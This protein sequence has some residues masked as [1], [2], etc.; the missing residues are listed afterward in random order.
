MKYALKIASPFLF[1]YTMA[2]FLLYS[3]RKKNSNFD[4]F[5]FRKS[6]IATNGATNNL[7]SRWIRASQKNRVAIST[8]GVLADV[9]PVFFRNTIQ[10]K[11]F[12]AFDTTLT[13]G[14]LES[15]KSDLKRITPQK[16]DYKKKKY[17]DDTEFPQKIDSPR[18]QYK[19]NDLME[20]N[21]MKT[22]YQDKSIQ[23]LAGAYLQAKPIMDLIACWWSYPVDDKS[24]R[25]AAAQMYH[26]DMDRVKFIKFFFYLSDVD[27][28]TGPHCYIEGSHRSLPFNFQDERRFTDEEVRKYFPGKERI[29]T[30]KKGTILAV[31]TRGLHKG[32]ELS[33]GH[34]LLLQ[35]E[36]S[37]SL[38]GKNY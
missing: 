7:I 23:N 16:L 8:T 18:Y 12:F 27:E 34:R 2:S 37:N 25:S 21:S 10:E 24:S 1:L 31:D 6:F 20:L 13:D 14:M 3:L 38:F 32:L 33:K 19:I 5:V 28:E 30:G 35:L 29:L 36:Y 9:D 17:V 22:L 26:F 11:G 4:Y 15:I